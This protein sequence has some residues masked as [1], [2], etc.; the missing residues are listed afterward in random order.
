MYCLSVLVYYYDILKAGISEKG[1]RGMHLAE[2]SFEKCIPLQSNLIG[3]ARYGRLMCAMTMMRLL[4]SSA[5]DVKTLAL[6]CTWKTVDTTICLKMNI[7]LPMY[8]HLYYLL[9]EKNIPLSFDVGQD[10]RLRL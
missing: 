10:K 4:R 8:H 5:R 2:V 9:P 3:P 1:A 7:S 6:V